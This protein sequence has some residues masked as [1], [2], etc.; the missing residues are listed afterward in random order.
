MNTV[1]AHLWIGPHDRLLVKTKEWLQKKLC[2]H[3]GCKQCICCQQ[4]EKQEHH[5]ILWMTPDRSY[6]IEQLQIIHHHLSYQLAQDEQF[7]FI[8]QKADHLTVQCSNNL[9]KS[10]EEPPAGYH[11]IL[12]SDRIDTILPTV[13]SRCQVEMMHEPSSKITGFKSLFD[14]FTQ[15]Q[16]DPA[17]FLKEL[18]TSKIE[19]KESIE[20]FD[21]LFD[22]WL[23]KSKIALINEKIEDYKKAVGVLTILKHNYMQLPMPGSSKVFWRNLYLQIK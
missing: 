15:E 10:L 2:L 21:A 12:L 7:F 11:F 17:Q 22:H 8:I 13:R 4:I 16:T 3:N 23:Q 18:D 9:L 20:L 5:S 19:T 1:P 6:N 14:F